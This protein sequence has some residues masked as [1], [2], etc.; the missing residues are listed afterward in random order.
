MLRMAPGSVLVLLKAS[1]S[2]IAQRMHENPH[3]HQVVEESDI[4]HVL[5]RFE[6]EFE[7]SLI[8]KR[9]VLDTSEPTVEET[10]AEFIQRH[11]PFQTEADL[12]RMKEKQNSQ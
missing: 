12:I 3:R 11:E 2:V 6:E 10:M 7:A 1:P 8:E 9:V 5:V 4:E